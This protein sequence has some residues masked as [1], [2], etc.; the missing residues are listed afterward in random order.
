MFTSLAKEHANNLLIS[1]V[2]FFSWFII[3]YDD[4]S[5]K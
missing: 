1:N 4:D 3:D 2:Q 5:T